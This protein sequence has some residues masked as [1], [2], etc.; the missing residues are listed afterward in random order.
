MEGGLWGVDIFGE[1]MQVKTLK[2]KDIDDFS[3]LA[4]K[5]IL[6][7]PYSSV[8]AKKCCIR[9]FKP[10][11]IRADIKKTNIL[12]M[13]AKTDG[14]I[15]GFIRGGF[16]GGKDSGIFFLQWIG[17]DA[18]YQSRGVANKMLDYLTKKLKASG[19]PIRLYAPSGRKI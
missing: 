10:A 1:F 19:K 2:E 7:S 18:Y 8:F 5:T 9:D 13:A 15:V 14:R 6:K 4:K 17:V 3:R 11:A 16:D 12:L